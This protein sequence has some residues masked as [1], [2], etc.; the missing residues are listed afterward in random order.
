M[1]KHI[2]FEIYEQ[3]SCGYV[4]Y[5]NGTYVWSAAVGTGFSWTELFSYY[6]YFQSLK[7]FLLSSYRLLIIIVTVNFFYASV[8]KST[9]RNIS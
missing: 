9:M 3:L 7:L 2:S 8:V 4:L 6:L 5:C 1:S